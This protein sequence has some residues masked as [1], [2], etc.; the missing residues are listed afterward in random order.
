MECWAFQCLWKSRTPTGQL[1]KPC[2]DFAQPEPQSIETVTV[3]AG[4][5]PIALD[6]ENKNT[7]DLDAKLSEYLPAKPETSNP[8]IT[9]LAKVKAAFNHL[10]TFFGTIFQF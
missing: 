7:L 4:V 5:E 9:G 3:T 6:L 1:S 8:D 2:P 10:H